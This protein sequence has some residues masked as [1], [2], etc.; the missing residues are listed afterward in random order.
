MAARIAYGMHLNHEANIP[1]PFISKEVRRRIMWS[2]YILDKFYAG[3]FTELTLCN[4]STMHINLPCEERNFELD[5]PTATPTLTPTSP[6]GALESGT[7]LMGHMCRLVKI[8]HDIL[9]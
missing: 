5:I 3:G 8:R 2:I 6:S 4:E 1:M 7:G 9:E